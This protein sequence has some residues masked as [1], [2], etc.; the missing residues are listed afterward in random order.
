VE[1]RIHNALF[2]SED[3]GAAEGGFLNDINEDSEVIFPDA[4]IESGFDE[5]KKRAPWPEAAGEDKLGKG[6]PES[7]RFQATRVAYF[8]SCLLSVVTTI[9]LLTKPRRW[10]RIAQTTRS[11]STASFP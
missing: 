11:Y 1:A 5:V 7:V 3:P 10:T 6:G 4:M 9:P 8:V 2:K